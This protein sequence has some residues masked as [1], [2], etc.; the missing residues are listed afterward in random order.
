MTISGD[1][2]R[3]ETGILSRSK[4]NIQLTKVQD[5]RV[6]QTLGQRMLHTGNLS[7]ETAGETSLLTV[8]NV[9]DPD[10]LAEEL[11]R[12]AHGEGVEGKSKQ[13]KAV[14][15][16]PSFVPTI[17]RQKQPCKP[18]SKGQS[19]DTGILRAVLEGL[20]FRSSAWSNP[21]QS[22]GADWRRP[23]WTTIAPCLFPP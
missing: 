10:L 13:P 21:L 11:S 2:L 9:D 20:N 1:K 7:V 19:L 12:A 14:I 18:M 17:T 22:P 6:D 16:F 23:S 4:R 3:Y 15:P 5:V 8:R